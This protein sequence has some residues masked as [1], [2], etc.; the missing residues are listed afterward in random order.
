MI[1]FETVKVGTRIHNNYRG[2]M[3]YNVSAT[4]TYVSAHYFYIKYDVDPLDTSSFSWMNNGHW[5]NII[6]DANE[7]VYRR[8]TNEDRQV[9]V[10]L[11]CI[12]YDEGNQWFGRT[13]IITSCTPTGSLFDVAWDDG[14]GGGGWYDIAN[15]FEVLVSH[16][17]RKKPKKIIP[18]I[19]LDPDLPILQAGYIQDR[20]RKKF[21]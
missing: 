6:I 11:R 13:A 12:Y 14:I 21:R 19:P 9:G 5:F 8:A 18:D 4:V 2:S 10:R 1:T 15:Q 3:Y 16:R 7:G 17:K 20:Q